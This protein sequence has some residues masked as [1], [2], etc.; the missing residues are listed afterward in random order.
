MNQVESISLCTLRV[1]GF[2][3]FLYM[4]ELKLTTINLFKRLLKI[5]L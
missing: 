3:G 1:C 4:V 2:Y 5:W